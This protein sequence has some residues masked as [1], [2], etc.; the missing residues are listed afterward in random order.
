MLAVPQSVSISVGA[1]APGE[2]KNDASGCSQCGAR[3]AGTLLNSSLACVIS[4]FLDKSACDQVCD[5]I[6]M[7]NRGDLLEDFGDCHMACLPMG[8][9]RALVH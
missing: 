7:Y 6:H 3:G 8:K 5:Q 1:A 4:G 2:R 9:N